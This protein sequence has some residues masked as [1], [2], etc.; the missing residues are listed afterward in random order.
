MLIEDPVTTCLSPSVYDMICKLGFEVKE[1][2]DINSIV[3]QR[4]EVCWQT[5]TDCVVYTESGLYVLCTPSI[6]LPVP[7]KMC[8]D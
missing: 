8:L 2:C 7:F 4:G 6:C 5:I 1:S 3:T